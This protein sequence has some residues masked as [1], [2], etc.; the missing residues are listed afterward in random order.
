M[1]RK[2]KQA[3]LI[4]EAEQ[5][6]AGEKVAVYCGTRNLYDD[7]EVA[8]RS[9]VANNPAIDRVYLLIE[10]DEFPHELPELVKAVNISGQDV[11]L[12]TSP[13]YNTPWTYMCMVRAA[14]TKIFPNLDYIFSL[15]VD[16]VVEDEIDELWDLDMS[17]SY[18]AAVREVVRE[19]EPVEAYYN[20]GVMFQN[21]AKLRADG[22]DDEVIEALNTRKFGFPEQDALNILCEHHI[23][24]LYGEWNINDFCT[25]QRGPRKVRHYAPE[26][27]MMP[28]MPLWQIYNRMTWEKALERRERIR[29]R[30]ERRKL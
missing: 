9:L 3:L 5:P 7:M 28:Q 25:P 30:N 20:V 2:K 10:D 29:L 14:F 21:L 27:H 23:Y 8:C 13:N 17:D 18:F 22:K 15:D 12:P 6:K 19:E 24:E 11:I 16:T 1:A 26:K 4:P